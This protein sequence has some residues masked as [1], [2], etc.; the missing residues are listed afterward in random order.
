MVIGK[1]ISVSAPEE[2]KNE[3]DFLSGKL[4]KDYGAEVGT[5]EGAYPVKLA[6]DPSLKAKNDEAYAVS[7]AKDG[8]VITGATPAAVLLGV[9]TLRGIIGVTQLPVSLQSVAIEDQPDFA[10]RGFMLDI[11]RNFKQRKPSRRF[12]TRCRTTSSTNSISTS[13]TTNRGGWKYRDFRN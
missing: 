9:Q 2:L 7:L 6:L 4:K 13:T 5:S 12:S 3:A 11:A 8:A 1:K 10:Y